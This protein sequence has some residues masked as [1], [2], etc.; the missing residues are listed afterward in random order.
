M[1]VLAILLI[2][3]IASLSVSAAAEAAPF[4]TYDKNPNVVAYYPTGPH[5]IPDEPGIH[6]EGKD[7]VMRAGKSGNFQQW[8]YGWSEENGGILEG[9]H[10]VWRIVKNDKT[11]GN[12]TRISDPH[13]EWGDYLTPGVDYLAKTNDFNTR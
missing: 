6:H 8:F 10:T 1:K 3:V 5:G 4:K 9:N 11:P 2:G 13:P 7:L 12:W